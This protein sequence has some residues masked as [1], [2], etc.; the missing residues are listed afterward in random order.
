M[1]VFTICYFLLI[2]V[3]ST[4]AQQPSKLSY[5]LIN[6]MKVLNKTDKDISL[7]VEGDV[8]EIKMVTESAGGVFKYSAGNVAAIKISI[9]Q[10]G[11]ITAIASVKRME[12]CSS[13]LEAL[14]DKMVVNNDILPV[15]FGFTPLTQGYDGSG[16]VVG[17]IDTGIDFEHPDFK[18][19][20]G[21]SRIKYIW[22]HSPLTGASSPQPYAYGQEWTNVDIDNGVATHFG[23]E[24]HGTHVS[25][26]AAG[27]GLAVNNY[28]GVA[29]QADI[30]VVALNFNQPDDDLL[31]SIVD[32]T[33]YIYSKADAMGKPCVINASVGTYFGS[34]DGK[35]LPGQLINNLIAAKNGRVFV[36]AAGNSGGVPFHLRTTVHS[37]TSFTWFK[38]PTGSLSFQVWADTANLKNIKLAIGADAT[39]PN[40]SFRGNT[41]FKNV[42]TTID[43]TINDSI[44]YKGKRVA[45]VSRFTELIG[46]R[47]AITFTIIPDSSDFLWRIISTGNGMFDIW[48]FDLV[49]DNLP[50]ASLFPD[51]T[52]YKMPDADQTIVSSFTCAPNVI[53]VGNYIN[54]NS[55]TDVNGTVQK[56]PTLVTGALYTTSSF[57]PTRDGRIKPEITATGTYV[58]SCMPVAEFA[59]SIANEPNKVAAGGKHIRNSGTSMSSPVVAG[60]AALYLQ[61]NPNA[62]FVEVKNAI[63]NGAK[64]DQ[65]TGNNLPNNS[66]GYGKADAFKT[67]TNTAVGI[68]A[69]PYNA[70]SCFIYPNPLNDKAIVEYDF[71]I[72]HPASANIQIIDVLGKVVKVIPFKENI[73]IIEF[74]RSDLNSGI[75]FYNLILD[76]KLSFTKKLIVL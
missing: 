26:I 61:K 44:I 75:Y 29:P 27:N 74:N 30:I 14:N 73:G 6:K 48:D 12:D 18:D 1:R 50:T 8:S 47:Y 62:N 49:F 60:I 23:E 10:I 22:Q 51:I 54:R 9:S 66:W 55:Y 52:H 40:Y 72:I 64:K 67:L 69:L 76:G 31:S 56:D 58:L 34:H 43:T 70:I 15:H 63:I 19:E 41:P 11:L 46:D 20:N 42:T 39:I 53:T 25:G 5:S 37:D 21:K 7:F 28:T 33:N 36:C 16:V 59:F 65:F 24:F 3:L 2:T 32:A 4:Q 17:I 45:K 35:D 71:G 38:R 57:G 68:D 13:K